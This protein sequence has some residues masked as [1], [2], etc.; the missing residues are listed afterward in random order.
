MGLRKWKYGWLRSG[1]KQ[2]DIKFCR[3]FSQLHK[4]TKTLK[5]LK[6]QKNDRSR[7]RAVVFHPIIS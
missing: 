3:I 2:V 6:M 1:P 5:T 7:R 4:E